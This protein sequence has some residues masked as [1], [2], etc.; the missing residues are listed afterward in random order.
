M[1]NGRV[2]V[3]LAR[4]ATLRK[5]VMSPCNA[6]GFAASHVGPSFDRRIFMQRRKFLSLS[7]GSVLFAACR[8]DNVGAQTTMPSAHEP[9]DLT[10]IPLWEGSGDTP[11]VGTTFEL[12]DAEWRARLT[13]EQY[14]VL[15]QEGT[16]YAFSGP[17]HDFHGVGT[18]RC[19]GCGAPVFSSEHKFDSGTGWPS[20]WQPIEEGRIE[21]RDDSSHGMT[22]TEVH[23]ARC[24]GHMGH[25]FPDG[26]RPTGLR[27]CINSV[28]LVFQP[29]T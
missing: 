8:P 15:R 9:V 13:P 5:T 25:V 7:A 23:C 28:S 4:P 24:G 14:R 27:Y 12:A 17:L 3:D 6:T 18:F 22:R 26:P 10:G 2:P 11:A 20:Y 19:A 21:E 29:A 16:E 1:C